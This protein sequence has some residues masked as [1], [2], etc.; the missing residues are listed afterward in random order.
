MALGSQMGG[1][2]WT[3][4]Y[5]YSEQKRTLKTLKINT[6][7]IGKKIQKYPKKSP[8]TD[9]IWTQNVLTM[10]VKMLLNKLMKNISKIHLK[11][12]TIC[13]RK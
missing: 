11:E 4:L 10:N 9:Q 1:K 6:I 5:F 2:K 7:A 12:I 13:R 8:K 3:E